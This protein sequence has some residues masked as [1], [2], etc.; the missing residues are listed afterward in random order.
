M[1]TVELKQKITDLIAKETGIDPIEI[2]QMF[3]TPKELSHGDLAFPC[4]RLS[5]TLRKSPQQI[6]GDLRAKFSSQSGMSGIARVE[7]A[8]GY[9][10]FTFDSAAVTADA[11]KR[12]LELGSSFGSSKLG[13]NKT[14]LIYQKI[15]WR[16]FSCHVLYN[17]EWIKTMM[18]IL[19]RSNIQ[20]QRGK[21]LE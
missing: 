7:Q 13:A 2:G 21:I 17:R 19:G 1:S 16:C 12:V 8:G 15:K 20:L 14:T 10:N 6:A 18:I 4:F 11:L 9:L 5:K 3:E